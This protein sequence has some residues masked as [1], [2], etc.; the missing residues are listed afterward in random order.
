[1]EEELSW[2]LIAVTVLA[3][4]FQTPLV[5]V[6]SHAL[7]LDQAIYVILTFLLTREYPIFQVFLRF[8]A[9]HSPNMDVLKKAFCH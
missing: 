9:V 7:Y 8:A 1:M 5:I 2:C 3:F 6:G 4:C